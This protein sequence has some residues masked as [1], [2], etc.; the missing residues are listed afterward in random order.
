MDIQFVLMIVVF[1]L[2]LA[3]L[4][5]IIYR[6]VAAKKDSCASGCGKC[7]ADFSKIPDHKS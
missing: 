7:S 4:G 5:R 1:A 6:S 2:A 3:Y